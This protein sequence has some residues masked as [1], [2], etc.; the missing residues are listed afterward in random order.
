L[1]VAK[2]EREA[3]VIPPKVVSDVG[4]V[5]SEIKENPSVLLRGPSEKS[6]AVKNTPG[7]R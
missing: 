3:R 1:R 2:R 6:P 7:H 5:T 4:S